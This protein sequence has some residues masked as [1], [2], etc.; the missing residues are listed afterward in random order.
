MPAWPGTGASRD[1]SPIEAESVV[2]SGNPGC[3]KENAEER[4]DEAAANFKM[5]WASAYVN[6]LRNVY[7]AWY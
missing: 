2:S 5:K 6:I 4:E 3:G 7:S 1:R